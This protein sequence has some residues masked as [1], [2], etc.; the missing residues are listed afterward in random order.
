MYTYKEKTDTVE[1]E[2]PTSCTYCMECKLKAEEL[3]MKDLVQIHEKKHPKG[4]EFIFTVEVSDARNGV[5]N[6]CRRQVR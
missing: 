6:D 2:H 4:Y 5:L 1:V 3:G